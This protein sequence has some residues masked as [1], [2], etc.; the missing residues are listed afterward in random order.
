LIDKLRKVARRILPPSD[1]EAAQFGY[2]CSDNF[3]VQEGSFIVFMDNRFPDSFDQVLRY[4]SSGFFQPQKMRL[5]FQHY[6]ANFET[7]RR[8]CD[9]KGIEWFCFGAFRHV[10][11]L[12][13]H[14][15]FYPFNSPTNAKLVANRACRHLLLLHGE[16]NKPASVKPLARLYDY[17][18]VAGDIACDRLIEEGIFTSS[19]RQD[20]RIIKMGD[21]VIGDFSGFERATSPSQAQTF[22]YFP[23]WEGGNDEENMSSLP[24][25]T[26]ILLTAL[27]RAGLSRLALRLHPHTGLRQ[28]DYRQYVEALIQSVLSEGYELVCAVNEYPT[29]LEHTLKDRYPAME[30]HKADIDPP[31]ALHSAIVD[32]SALEAVLDAKQ[33]PNLVYIHPDSPIAAPNSY[34]ALKADHHL[35]DP[36]NLDEIPAIVSASA[37]YRSALIGYGDPTL[38]DMVPAKRMDWLH[39][40]VR[41]SAFWAKPLDPR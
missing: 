26:P 22:G 32:V 34:W 15:V 31:M 21:T 27:K 28:H 24:K 4:V 35:R 39:G 20:G 14:L 37:A 25:I 30:W 19:D 16:S 38:E 18:L 5:V 40:Y 11:A 8:Q 33:I 10:P 3:G 17:V 9:D 2:A 7:I 36:V 29:Q 6:S 23:T 13:G 12:S 1:K 41:Q